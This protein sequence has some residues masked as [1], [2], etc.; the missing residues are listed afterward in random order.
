MPI[1]FD[2][3]I[4]AATAEIQ[5]ATH[6][7]EVAMRRLSL[8]RDRMRSLLDGTPHEGLPERLAAW[9][10]DAGKTWSW[11]A[12]ECGKSVSSLRWYAA[13]KTAT[14][15][16]KAET[17]RDVAEKIEALS[18]GRIPVGEWPYLED[19]NPPKSTRPKI[20]R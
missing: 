5:D 12:G 9:L 8:A 10:A 3:Q 4:A 13:G 7:V 2:Q 14:W 15:G 1:S 19:R 20:K 18:E 17:P 11:L 16:N 6:E